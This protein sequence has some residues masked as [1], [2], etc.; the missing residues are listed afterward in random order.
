M[1][2]RVKDIA[3]GEGD[4]TK[5]IQVNS[6]DEIGEL[7][8]WFNTFLEKLQD[9]IGSV[10]K[11]TVELGNSSSSLISTAEGMSQVA[12]RS[13]EQANQAAGSANQVSE[14]ATL[15]AAGVEE[16]GASIREIAKSANQ[17]ADVATSA[18]RVANHTNDTVEQLGTS[19]EDIG[20]IIQVITSIAEQ[21]NLLALNATIEAAR[22]GDAGKGFAV[23]A[24]EVKELAGE[25]AKATDEISNK[26]VAI[27]QDAKS[28]ISAI[29]EIGK[30]IR[31]INDLQTSIAGAVEEQSATMAEI[32]RSVNSAAEGSS[33][34][35]ANIMG[36]A[37]AAGAT[38]RD[39]DGTQESAKGLAT[40]SSKLT[41]LVGQFKYE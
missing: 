21:T 4:L 12:A 24:N 14:S 29:A 15:A 5:R 1:V 37:E 34:I 6:K 40:M 8:I 22:A 26:I 3:E 36:V 31:D 13:S 9:I 30:I 10:G 16:M 38:T 32:G 41:G 18:V 25:T 35:A 27:Q 33:D 39:A 20:K 23:V 28:S 11:T 17:A 2:L 19:S 7:G